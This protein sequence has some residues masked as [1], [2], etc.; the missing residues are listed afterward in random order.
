MSLR[1]AG[2][3]NHMDVEETRQGVLPLLGPGLGL[4]SVDGRRGRD[5]WFFARGMYLYNHRTAVQSKVT[6]CGGC[7]WWRV[8]RFHGGTCWYSVPRTQCAT[9]ALGKR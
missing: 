8:E 2:A 3:R 6:S 5:I 9:N 4:F 1:R 7:R